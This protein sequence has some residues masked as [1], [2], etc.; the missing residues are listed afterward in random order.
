MEI[1]QLLASLEYGDAVASQALAIQ[2]RLRAWGHQSDIF[3]PNRH[4]LATQPIRPLDEMPTSDDAVTIYHHA[5]WSDEIHERLGSLSGRIAM[6]YH[7]VTPEHYFAPYSAELRESATRARDALGPLRSMVAAPLTV[8]EFN[9]DELNEAGYR[10]V[11]LLPLPLDLAAFESMTPATD[12]LARYDDGVTNFLFVGR[13]APNKRQEDVIRV[14]A[15]YHRYIDSASRLLLVGAA[16]ELSEYREDL[17]AVARS[18]V[19][20]DQVVFAG[21]VS[22]PELV[23]YYRV[24][25]LFLC[26]SEHEGFCAPLVEAMFHEL[27][28]I[29]RAEG[30]VPETLGESGVL[31]RGR[32]VPKIAEAAR[33]LLSDRQLRSNVV[34]RQRGRLETFTPE[35][36]EDALRG[37]VDGL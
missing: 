31:V 11:G 16:P 24:A 15:W 27:P 21:K 3:A 6:V 34:A 7:N 17:E 37:F 26:M 36:F 20:E 22:F 4:P 35:R 2:E 1:H 5:F 25:D 28:V 19:V 8:S 18:L 23:A 30:A 14:F 29:A 33:L 13:L 32:N 10:D 9:R 12:V